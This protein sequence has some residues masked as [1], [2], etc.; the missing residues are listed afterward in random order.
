[1]DSARINVTTLSDESSLNAKSATIT[2]KPSAGFL[3]HFKHYA[4]NLIVILLKLVNNI[5]RGPLRYLSF[6]SLSSLAFLNS[7][8]RNQTWPCNGWTANSPW[9]FCKLQIIWIIVWCDP[10]PLWMTLV[11]TGFEGVVQV[12]RCFICKVFSPL[13]YYIYGLIHFSKR[14]SS[15]WFCSR[16]RMRQWRNRLH[17]NRQHFYGE[18]Y[19]DHFDNLFKSIGD[20]FKAMVKIPYEITFYLPIFMTYYHFSFS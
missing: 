9:T 13:F 1:M 12:R 19:R 10:M 2:K 6:F 16:S 20:W 8:I 14:F 5:F 11:V 18:K 17:E 15:T 7:N 3:D 4:Q